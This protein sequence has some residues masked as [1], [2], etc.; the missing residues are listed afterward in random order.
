MFIP[1][2]TLALAGAL[3]IYN[4]TSMQS[5]TA[6]C[7]LIP[8]IAMRSLYISALIMV[9]ISI[10][11]VRGVISYFYDEESINMS[12][13]FVT[14]LII[15]PVTFAVT[16]W[17][18]IRG[19]K[20][21][22]CHSCAIALGATSERGV[23]G[24]LFSQESRY[25]RIFLLAISG[26]LSLLTWGYYTFFYI[27]VNINVPDRFFF[28]WVPVILFLVSIFYLGSRCFTL[29]SYYYRNLEDA[30]R[31]QGA[32]TSL[33]FI[34]ISR[35]KIY[36]APCK[37]S[38]EIPGIDIYDT[39]ATLS[40]EHTDR[41]PLEKAVSLFR[42]I[43]KLNE[44]EGLSFRYMYTSHEASGDR[45]TF[46]FI[47]E[48]TLPDNLKG[49]A[50][51]GNWLSLSQVERL[52]H[53]HELTPLLAAEI[54]RLYTVTMAWKTYDSRGRRLYKVKNYHPLFRLDGICDWDVDFDSPLWLNVARI[55]EDK[56]LY[57]LRRFLQR[58]YS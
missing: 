32:S 9:A 56:P 7:P 14:A 36:L 26:M 38:A 24:S 5:R 52:L 18:M 17:A 10:I 21:S 20:Y 57:R 47:C 55:N 22:A 12:I 49:S 41:M 28:G 25:Q 50:I 19:R 34:L 46:H 45:N 16:A 6:V 35:N 54:H 43:S 53:N 27:N 2:V 30:D 31:Q 15:S 42:D 33:R 11:Y 48:P 1:P 3:F 40:I 8:T 4:K 51:N 29:W 39:P 58:L 13:P 44:P 23:I 37:D